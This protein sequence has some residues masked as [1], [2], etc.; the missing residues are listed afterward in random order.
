MTRA[1]ILGT[2]ESALY[3]PDLAAAEAFFGGILGLPVIGRM[4]GRH[5]FFRVGPSILL[6]F[7]PE[8][9]LQPAR[10]GAL[11][12][13]THGTTGPGHYCMTIAS[14]DRAAWIAHLAANGVEI[15]TQISWPGGG[16]SLYIRDPAGN[17]IELAD[18]ALWA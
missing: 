5:L 18:A 17:S 8:A 9:T 3:A 7:N 15:E 4:E 11:P 10:P 14:E 13:P 12:I 16:H 6:V 1:P 2:L